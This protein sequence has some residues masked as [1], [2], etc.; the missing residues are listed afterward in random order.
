MTIPDHTTGASPGA[1]R[2]PGRHGRHI[3]VPRRGGQSVLLPLRGPPPVSADA[4]GREAGGR[5]EAY[6]HIACCIDRS[7][8]A[9]RALAEAARL[10]RLGSGRLSVVHVASPPVVSGYSRW[11]PEYQPFYAEAEEWLRTK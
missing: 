9:E 5:R 11:G 2:H 6:R 10:W 1:P 4:R 7:A 3:S 8:A